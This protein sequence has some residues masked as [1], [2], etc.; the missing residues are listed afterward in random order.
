MITYKG[1]R[2]NYEP[3]SLDVTK[4]HVRKVRHYPGT[5]RSKVSPLG[6]QATEFPCVIITQSDA[7]K[8]ILDQILDD[9]TEG[10]LIVYDRLYVR[11]IVSENFKQAPETPDGSVWHTAMT[12]IALDPRPR[13]I[14]TREV[15]Y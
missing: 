13:N 9:A 3:G 5:N 2:F 15:L 1:I 14:T 6:Q 4:K 11:S 12:F 10:D 8:L 7:E